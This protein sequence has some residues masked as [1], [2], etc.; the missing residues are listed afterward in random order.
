MNHLDKVVIWDV[1]K[2]N[3][4][5][6]VSSEISIEADK[7]PEIKPLLAEPHQELNKWT[8]MVFGEC[9]QGKSTTLNAI[10]E[11]VS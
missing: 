9:G 3:S 5:N 2:S 4:N 6:V 11:I 7:I 10:V 1:V 8:A